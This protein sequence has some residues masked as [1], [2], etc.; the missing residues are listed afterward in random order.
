MSRRLINLLI[1]VIAIM[2]SIVCE[3]SP[4]GASLQGIASIAIAVF[5][6]SSL[7]FHVQHNLMLSPEEVD[8][9]LGAYVRQVE[10]NLNELRNQKISRIQLKLAE[11]FRILNKTIDERSS[12]NIDPYL[13]DFCAHQEAV[14]QESRVKWDL[15]LLL[16][17][18]DLYSAE[19]AK[20]DSMENSLTTM[21]VSVIGGINWPE[22]SCS[23]VEFGVNYLEP[24]TIHPRL[25][26]PSRGFSSSWVAAHEI[27]HSLGVHH[28]GKPFNPD[29]DPDLWVM[30]ATSSVNRINSHWSNCSIDS[31][32]YLDLDRFLQTTNDDRDEALAMELPGQVFDAD[33]QCKT[34]SN[35]L[36]VSE[37]HVNSLICNKTLWCNDKTKLE[38]DNLVAIGPALEGTK[39]G[40]D[41]AICYKRRCEKLA[42][43]QNES[44]RQS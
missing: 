34:F 37:E 44:L 29:C 4:L 30:S 12:G 3:S 40:P 31:L 5:T 8:S 22:L 28:D 19:D 32:S 13:D 6:D 1:A 39:C 15:S 17:A 21:G 16:T 43:N 7:N 2:Q 25:A 18:Q 42:G 35:K 11:T 36:I 26:N 38:S 33:F 24:D 23:I 10:E 14:R 27:A 9:L 41:G 20:L